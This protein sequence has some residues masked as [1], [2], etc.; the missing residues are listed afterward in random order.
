MV[1][2]MQKLKLLVGKDKPT[3]LDYGSGFGR[4]ARAAVEAGFEVIAFEPSNKRC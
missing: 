4:W 3:L 2:E 1:K